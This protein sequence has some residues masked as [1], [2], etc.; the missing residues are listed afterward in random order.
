MAVPFVLWILTKM[1][2]S[3]SAR[4]A[5]VFVYIKLSLTVLIPFATVA[6][7]MGKQKLSIIFFFSGPCSGPVNS[8]MRLTNVN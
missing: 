8:V 2:K 6:P 5:I 4:P 7:T 3:F 1:G